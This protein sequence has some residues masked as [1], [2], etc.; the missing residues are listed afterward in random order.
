M[1]LD[2]RPKKT[3]AIRRR[4]TPEQVIYRIMTGN[5]GDV[6]EVYGNSLTMKGSEVSICLHDGKNEAG[7]DFNERPKQI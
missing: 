2:L 6:F 1:P 7:D 4:L 3:R 5:V